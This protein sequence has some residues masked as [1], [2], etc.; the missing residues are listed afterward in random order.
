MATDRLPNEHLIGSPVPKETSVWATLLNAS[1]HTEFLRKV[2]WKV[3][4]EGMAIAEAAVML[5]CDGAKQELMLRK[6]QTSDCGRS[7]KWTFSSGAT[8][9]QNE[10]ETVLIVPRRKR[11]TVCVSSQ[12]GCAVG[13]RFCATGTMGLQRNLSVYQILEQ[14][15]WARQELKKQGTHLRNV[16][17]GMGEPLHNTRAVMDAIDWLSRDDGF[18][19]SLKHITVSTAGVPRPMTEIA[20]RFPKI[21]IALSLHTADAAQRR[22]LVPRATSDL[23]QLQN[24]I[25][26]IN[27]LQNKDPL[28]IEY[29]LLDGVNDSLEHA[30]KLYEFCQG[31][32]VEV[33][34]IPWNPTE[35]PG[36]SQR[37]AIEFR[38]SKMETVQGFINLLRERQL[39]VTLRKSLGQS[40][41]AACGQLVTAK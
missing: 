13:C 28:W 39:V 36:S 18:G 11:A 19:I 26:T 16:F 22:W 41:M 29:V 23:G 2:R 24:T 20:R 7:V 4:R 31:L 15:Y 3:L 14:V 35:T 6:T 33:N 32:S 8:D 30:A 12:I 1:H 40:I 25:R 21:R 5:G 9:S 10:L 38:P 27:D 37:E 17:M 34:V